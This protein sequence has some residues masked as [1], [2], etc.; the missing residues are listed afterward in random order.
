MRKLSPDTLRFLRT[1]ISESAPLNPVKCRSLCSGQHCL[2]FIRS[3][4]S[5]AASPLYNY[6]P[7]STSSAPHSATS[8]STIEASDADLVQALRSGT[9][10]D[11]FPTTIPR[12]PPPKGTFALDLRTLRREFLQL[13]ARAHPDRHP[14]EQKRAAEAVSARINDAYKTLQS[15]LAR[16]A[17]LLRLRGALDG[18][19]EEG[20]LGGEAELKLEDEEMLLEVM[21]VREQAEEAETEEEVAALRKENQKRIDACV[22]ILEEAF[23]MD[24]LGKAKK[25]VVKLRYW[26]GVEDRLR[27]GNSMH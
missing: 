6:R 13:Q 11:L 20:L 9:H 23:G 8:T 19:D 10:Y 15:P 18:D 21:E 25:E 4:K 3:T 27:E 14:P 1:A 5:S 2:T 22:R 7:F 16:A 17:Y 12:G 26:V 24:D